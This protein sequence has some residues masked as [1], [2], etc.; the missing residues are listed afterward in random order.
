MCP[1]SAAD[2]TY[3]GY[4]SGFVTEL[5]DSSVFLESIPNNLSWSKSGLRESQKALVRAKEALETEIDRLRKLGATNLT[6]VTFYPSTNISASFRTYLGSKHRFRLYG[7]DQSGQVVGTSGVYPRAGASIADRLVTL[8]QTSC[9]VAQFNLFSPST[10]NV[11]SCRI[12]K[13]APSNYLR[14]ATQEFA[15]EVSTEKY[16]D[17]IRL[18]QMMS[19][20]CLFNDFEFSTKGGRFVCPADQRLYGLSSFKLTEKSPL[21]GYR[22]KFYPKARAATLEYLPAAFQ[23]LANG[24]RFDTR[25]GRLIFQTNFDVWEEPQT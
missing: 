13:V 12:T 18:F 11:D 23:M 2:P 22:F 4:Q 21:G 6:K 9:S 8:Q 1:A 20:T 17:K 14:V 25:T 16:Y 19:I 10:W 15:D 7:F 5:N 3:P 24:V